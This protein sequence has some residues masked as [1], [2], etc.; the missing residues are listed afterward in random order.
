VLA[1][2]GEAELVEHRLD[3]AGVLR[4]DL[5]VVQA[6]RHVPLGDPLQRRA[7]QQP[8]GLVLQPHQRAAR[9]PRGAGGVGLAEGV[10]EDLQRQRPVVAG[11][12]QVTD[13]PDEVEVALPREE[14]VVPAPAQHVHRQPRRVGELDVED[15]LGGD[16]LDRGGVVPAGEDVEAVQAGAHGGVV[17]ALDDAPGAAVVVDVPSP[18]QRLERDPAAVR[19]R[20]V[21]EPSQL[22]GGDLVGVDAGG[23]HVRADQHGVDAQP[24]HHAQPLLGA[25]QVVGEL[26]L[27]DAL[28]VAEGLVEVQAQ[29]QPVR[30]GA[31]LLGAEVADDQ[32]GLE[33]LDAVEAGRRGGIELL[34]QA[35]GE[36]DRRDRVTHQRSL[37]AARSASARTARS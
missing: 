8:G 26:L 19:R 22:R 9:V 37:P 5:D 15:L 25:A 28:E 33:D 11:R 34:L 14:P 20:E 17:G 29:A 7:R 31:D 13:E 32:V 2:E 35:A 24:L 27:G 10:V 23:R 36:A 30:A 3:G 18:G 16:R 6:C 21:P 12:D 4:L 1:A